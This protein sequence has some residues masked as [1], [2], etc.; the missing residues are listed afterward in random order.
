MGNEKNLLQDCHEMWSKKQKKSARLG[1]QA[2]GSSGSGHSIRATSHPRGKAGDEL[3]EI[4]ISDFIFQFS[5]NK[6]N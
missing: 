6:V 3:E 5:E 2:E 1:R 4:K